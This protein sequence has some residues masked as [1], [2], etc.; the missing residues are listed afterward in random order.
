MPSSPQGKT[1]PSGPPPE[2]GAVDDRGPAGADTAAH[3]LRG[4]LDKF[5]ADRSL[6]S[7]GRMSL[8]IGL[9]Q[10]LAQVVDRIL[11]MDDD[12]DRVERQTVYRQ[13]A[14]NLTGDVDI[15]APQLID[16]LAALCG[17][18]EDTGESDAAADTQSVGKVTD[19]LVRLTVTYTPNLNGPSKRTIEVALATSSRGLTI[20]KLQSQL[21]WEDLPNDVREAFLRGDQ[22]IGFRLFP[23]E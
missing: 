13:L 14:D 5:I 20:R 10:Q 12:P 3:T 6:P 18:H 1:L 2:K 21:P 22:S 16:V 4:A 11:S 23:G 9:A 15:P 19:K 17:D 7:S 8:A